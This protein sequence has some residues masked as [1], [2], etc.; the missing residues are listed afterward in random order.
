MRILPLRKDA[1]IRIILTA[2]LYLGSLFMMVSA[3]L[4]AAVLPGDFSVPSDIG[5]RDYIIALSDN[6]QGGY[7]LQAKQAE[8]NTVLV[9]SAM[10]PFSVSKNSQVIYSYH[11]NSPY[12]RIHIIPL[13]PG[14]NDLIISTNQ[15]N[16]KVL[17]TAANRADSR[18]TRAMA[19][20]LISFGINIGIGLIGLIMYFQKRSEKYL[21]IMS[22]AAMVSAFS[23]L[24]TASLPLPLTEYSYSRIQRIWDSTRPIYYVLCLLLPSYQSKPP[25][26]LG[27]AFHLIGTGF[28][29]SGYYLHQ[30]NLIIAVY[31][32]LFLFDFAILES[33]EHTCWI[34]F[35]TGM[36]T[37]YNSYSVYMNFTNFGILPNTPLLIYLYT[38]HVMITFVML[39]YTFNATYTFARKYEEAEELSVE[40]DK[41]VSERTQELREQQQ[42][43]DHMLINIFHDLRNP[44]FSALGLA[45]MIIPANEV[46]EKKII[47]MKEKLSFLSQLSEQLLLMGKLGDSQIKFHFMEIDYSELTQQL[48]D[49]FMV[50]CQAKRIRLIAE[51][52]KGIIA[53]LDSFRTS[54][55]IRNIFQNAY[56]FT[57]PCAAIRV[58]LRTEDHNAVLEV[59][60][61]G[62]GIKESELPFIFDRYYQG[63]LSDQDKS[64]GLGLSIAKEIVLQE[65]G[66]ITA[67]SA[68]GEGTTIRISFPIAAE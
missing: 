35:L 25:V 31:L 30:V 43:K 27:I 61:Q 67:V 56:R 55:V 23:A 22:V 17:I 1:I 11:S 19:T 57:P 10:R 52:E 39:A 6:V 51:I 44:I 59:S 49:E 38:P 2:A 47:V 63:S 20:N 62:K 42:K 26:R 46:E 29:A 45:D 36:L 40:L 48:C 28:I 24:F 5:T 41:K 21:L 60:D 4:N 16:L 7:R 18:V 68:E 33:A 58:S 37:L 12:R 66:H 13:S 32:V 3:S 34:A 50:D 64:S 54:Q 53:S 15:E 65:H 9:L 8:E 14:D